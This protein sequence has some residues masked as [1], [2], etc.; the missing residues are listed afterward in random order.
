M[1]NMNLPELDDLDR[2]VYEW[3]MWADGVGE[4]GQRKLKA[5]TV[6]VSRVGG[7]GGIVAYQL[8]A[9]GVGHLV[10]AHAGNIRPSD[11]NRQLLMTFDRIGESRLV[12]AKSRLL[13]LNPRIQVEIVEDNVN[14]GNANAL[15]LK[16]DI[17]VD[18][19]PMFEERFAM[20]RAI[21]GQNKPMVECAMF[22]YEASLT[23]ILPGRT[24]CLACLS[25]TA[26][27]AWRR[28]FPVFGAV[29]GAVGCLAAMEVIKLIV[30]VGNPLAGRLLMMD[31]ASMNISFRGL[32][33]NPD[34]QIC[35]THWHT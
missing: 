22:E 9:A 6:L 31:L 1:D 27:K 29:S 16:A 23:T 5:A 34:C 11:L 35:R 21:V 10:L 24:P 8:A 2:S 15:V 28:E 17:V 4:I 14:E 13:E 20:N 12:T 32:H 30:G 3:Q 19:A 25:P 7:L 18:A 33:R 26:P